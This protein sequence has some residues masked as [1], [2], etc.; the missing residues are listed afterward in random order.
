MNEA[1]PPKPQG[2]SPKWFFFRRVWDYCFGGKFPIKGVGGVVVKWVENHY[3]ISSAAPG[4]QGDDGQ[5]GELQW[6]LGLWNSSLVVRAQQAVEYTPAGGQAGIY[7]ALQ[8]VPIGTAPDTG[9]PYW[10][11][12]PNPLATRWSF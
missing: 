7:I 4:V 1:I 12:W 2:S 8:D 11:A 6:F 5:A 9:A 3:E 10:Y